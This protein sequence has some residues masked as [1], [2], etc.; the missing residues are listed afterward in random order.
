[1]QKGES[2]T[3]GLCVKV[4]RRKAFTIADFGRRSRSAVIIARGRYIVISGKQ[5]HSSIELQMVREK[6]LVEISMYAVQI[7]SSSINYTFCC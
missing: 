4:C 7:A 3:N 5:S 2:G 1:M 6:I